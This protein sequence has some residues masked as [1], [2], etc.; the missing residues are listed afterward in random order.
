M[1]QAFDYGTHLK[2]LAAKKKLEDDAPYLQTRFGRVPRDEYSDYLI[3]LLEYGRSR[4]DA[5]AIIASM[6]AAKAAAS[7]TEAQKAAEARAAKVKALVQKA[8]QA[9][10]EF[11]S[12]AY[13]LRELGALGEHAG[14]LATSLKGTLRSIK[15]HV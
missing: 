9:L 13:Q 11:D 6:R 5:D 8:Q 14:A 2:E 7:Q 12:V 15:S 10:G 3:G 4:T 1:A